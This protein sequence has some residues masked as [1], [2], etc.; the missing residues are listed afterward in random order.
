MRTYP[1]ARQVN[2]DVPFQ[3]LVQVDDH[4]LWFV[5]GLLQAVGIKRARKS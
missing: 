1:A 3:W 2:P 4:E 5:H